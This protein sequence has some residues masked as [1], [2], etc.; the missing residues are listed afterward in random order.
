[1]TTELRRREETSPPVWR[2]PSVR[3]TAFWVV[4]VGAMFIGTTFVR[5]GEEAATAGEAVLDPA[6]YATEIYEP[7]VVPTIEE[8]ATDL[9]ELLPR[10]EADPEGTGEE[11][12]HRNGSSPYSYAVEATGT[13]VEGPFGQVGLEVEGLE[14]DATV[15]VQT[16][17]AVIGTALRDAVGFITFDQARNQ[18]EFAN[19][20]TELNNQVKA[21]VLTQTDFDSLLGEEITVLGAFT[22][23]DP[24]HLTITP[25]EI[26]TGDE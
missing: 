14:S 2:R 5:P 6:T 10:I 23:D 18:I 19:I 20:A 1:M 8:N 21:A 25:V 15:G 13:V 26:R 4:L 7:D 22:Y 16:G 17:P 12:G 3:R 9:T 24:A 11:L